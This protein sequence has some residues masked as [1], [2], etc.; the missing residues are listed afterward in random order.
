MSP[1]IACATDGITSDGSN[2]GG[3]LLRTVNDPDA[4][5]VVSVD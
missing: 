4:L 2:V 1:S 3:V 5:E